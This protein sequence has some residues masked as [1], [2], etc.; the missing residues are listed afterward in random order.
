MD[1]MASLA[2]SC[3]QGERRLGLRN[4]TAGRVNAGAEKKRHIDPMTDHDSN[5]TAI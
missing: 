2:R 3:K 5:T 4:T 1:A